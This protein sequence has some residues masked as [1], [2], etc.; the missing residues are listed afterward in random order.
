M[1]RKARVSSSVRTRFLGTKLRCVWVWCHRF[2][3]HLRRSTTK[4]INES[5][6]SSSSSSSSSRELIWFAKSIVKLASYFKTMEKNIYNTHS[7][8][9]LSPLFM[10]LFGALFPIFGIEAFKTGRVGSLYGAC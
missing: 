10:G 2:R 3:S 8:G 6:I 7:P 1:S 9:R 4:L 5:G